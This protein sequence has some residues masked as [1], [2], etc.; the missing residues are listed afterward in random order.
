MIGLPRSSLCRL[1]RGGS[2]AAIDLVSSILI[3]TNLGLVLGTV[4]SFGLIYAV[5][6][7]VKSCL[8][9]RL[10]P[11]ESHPV[12]S[13]LVFIVVLDFM[14]YWAHRLMHRS[15]EL[16]QVHKFHHTATSMTM[17]TALRDHPLERVILQAFKAVPTAL[18]G[19]P[20]QQ[21][22]VVQLLLQSLGFLKHSNLDANWGW[23]GRWLIQSPRA[24]H[25]HH[26][27]RPEHF[28]ANFASIFQF[29]DVI[30]GTSLHSTDHHPIEFGL[31][32][33]APADGPIRAIC[34]TTKDFYISLR[35]EL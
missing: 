16:W 32:E 17:L 9:L 31:P 1:Q 6:R 18:L 34:R 33:S 5:T 15:S 28:D 19:V 35:P 29:W 12:L 24:H 7:L 22:L 3:L 26:S 4:M 11:H 21:Y 10:L 14:N 27:S 23:I 20:P 2:G 8:N 30:F 25:F 13:Y